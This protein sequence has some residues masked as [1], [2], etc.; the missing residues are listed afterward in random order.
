[1]KKDSKQRLFEVMGRLDPSFNT[2]V[3]EISQDL[4]NKTTQA[5]RDKGMNKRADKLSDDNIK[6]LMEEFVDL[7]LY[8]NYVIM[9]FSIKNK[10]EFNTYEN[11]NINKLVIHVGSPRTQ[12]YNTTTFQIEYDIDNDQYYTG[13]DEID[14]KSARILSK[15]ATK[16]NPNTKYKDGIGDFKIKGWY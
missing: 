10:P 16:I 11:K 5:M 4:V 12:Q 3:N 7:P 6:R 15:I 13:Y 14:R 2:D 8:E 9:G 1:M